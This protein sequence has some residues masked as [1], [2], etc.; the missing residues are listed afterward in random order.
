MLA[1]TVSGR[2][3]DI[4]LGGFHSTHHSYPEKSSDL[5]MKD[6]DKKV[7][8]KIKTPIS[9]PS[10]TPS[11]VRAFIGQTQQEIRGAKSREGKWGRMNL[12]GR[13]E[14]SRVPCQS[15]E[16]WTVFYLELQQESSPLQKS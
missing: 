4:A 3:T 1:S 15:R 13:T 14:D 7:G 16:V 2:P 9:L 6:I 10:L 8:R 11:P 12:K 5:R